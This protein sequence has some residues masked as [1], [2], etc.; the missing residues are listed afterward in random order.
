M[1]KWWGFDGK[2]YDSDK[3][4]GINIVRPRIFDFLSGFFSLFFALGI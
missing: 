4:D 3:S 2:K 1:D